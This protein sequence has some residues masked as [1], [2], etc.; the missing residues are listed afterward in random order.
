[1]DVEDP[2][3]DLVVDHVVDPVV[4]TVVDLVVD[5]VGE[6]IVNLFTVSQAQVGT[7]GLVVKQESPET[8]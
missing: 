2:V 4:D 6:V 1:V 8:S 5:L 3:A 7:Q